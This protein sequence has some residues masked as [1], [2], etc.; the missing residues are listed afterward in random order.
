MTKYSIVIPTFNRSKITASVVYNF[1]HLLKDRQ[2]FE[3]LVINDGSTDDTSSVVLDIKKYHGKVRL[4]NTD[5]ANGEY[6]NPGFSR[7][8]GIKFSKG[9]I[10][11]FCDGDIVHLTDP[12]QVMDKFFTNDNEDSLYITG[13]YMR[14]ES[15]NKVTGPHGK[16]K[17][18]PHGSW[19]GVSKKNLIEM[20]GY[21]ERYKIYGNEDHDIVQRFERIGLKHISTEEIIGIHPHFDS[22]RDS[23]QDS[24]VIKKIQMEYQRES[25]VIR[26]ATIHWGKGSEV[27]STEEH[28]KDSMSTT[29]KI[30]N[31]KNTLDSIKVQKLQSDI[32]NI[33]NILEMLSS[34]SIKT[35]RILNLCS[36]L[37]NALVGSQQGIFKGKIHKPIKGENEVFKFVKN[38]DKEVFSDLPE[39]KGSLDKLLDIDSGLD[40]VVLSQIHRQRNVGQ[41][42]DRAFKALK[43]NGELALICPFYSN[44]VGSGNSNNL[45]NAGTLLYNLILA[46][47]DCKKAKVSTFQN[48]IQI[49]VIKNDRKI[50][51]AVS[52]S[53]LYDFFPIE[54]YQHFDGNILEVNWK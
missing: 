49:Y 8:T 43:V 11:C 46:G 16:N 38:R 53:L 34:D 29:E 9:K 18:M 14:A 20:G 1:L 17:N 6:R 10:V 44:C 35:S 37:N 31:D 21:D 13:V 23:T 52:L 27:N 41:Y 47:F 54:V 25:S 33:N 51:N 15:N 30:E 2:D 32:G 7:N 39:F 24:E 5:K 42:L 50:P 22:G 26:N 48:Q 3:L 28:K 36:N 45:W 40:L 4:I 12:L 19:L